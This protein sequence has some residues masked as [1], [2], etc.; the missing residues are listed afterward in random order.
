MS[1]VFFCIYIYIYDSLLNETLTEKLVCEMQESG[2]ESNE[3]AKLMRE[4]GEW[5]GKGGDRRVFRNMT[6]RAVQDTHRSRSLPINAVGGG[7]PTSERTSGY[8][9]LRSARSSLLSVRSEET[10]DP[11]AGDTGITRGISSIRAKR[12]A[13]GEKTAPR[14]ALLQTVDLQLKSSCTL[15]TPTLIDVPP[16]I[17]SPFYRPK[18]YTSFETDVA[19]KEARRKMRECLRQ[20]GGDMVE[21]EDVLSAGNLFNFRGSVC[22]AETFRR[23]EFEVQMWTI[24]GRITTEFMR[25][26]VTN[27]PEWMRFYK[28]VKRAF[29]TE[30][31]VSEDGAT[32][33]EKFDAEAKPSIEESKLMDSVV[34]MMGMND[35]DLNVQ[36]AMHM[37]K[38][39]KKPSRA[40]AL[41]SEASL[42]RLLA[43]VDSVNSDIQRCCV[44]A[45]ANM[46]RPDCIP[47]DND[48]DRLIERM[49]AF[50]KTA[51]LAQTKR[52]IVQAFANL[53]VSAE[54]Q[55]GTKRIVANRAK[56]IEHTINY[57][58]TCSPD[59]VGPD[60]CGM[61]RAT[62]QK[63]TNML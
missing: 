31:F 20:C 59:S 13:R 34:Y 29:E 24:N 36:A 53:V 11:F 25:R 5:S 61:A 48:V 37:A 16:S 4:E 22:D 41:W 60:C 62:M 1:V 26:S 19:P 27:G 47:S 23:I 54:V 51:S 7:T 21:D 15:S 14:T 56:D 18:R 42:K 63:I 30:T 50:N 2:N 28:N 39:S 55:P 17:P 10:F 58:V 40:E 9:G 8:R 43:S 33:S 32:T 44:A 49:C 52:H 3:A 38:L 46:C 6:F 57:I 35:E 45:C 12:V